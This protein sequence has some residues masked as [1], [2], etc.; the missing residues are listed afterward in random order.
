MTSGVAIG[1]SWTPSTAAVSAG[2]PTALT[3]PGRATNGSGRVSRFG[4][5]AVRVSLASGNVRR[6]AARATRE[7]GPES[8]RNISSIGVMPA[9]VSVA[10]EPIEYATA[11]RS[12]PST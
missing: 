6:G 4:N 3:S 12:R 9:I 1:R 7:G 8:S 5:R 10:N 11:P 2:R